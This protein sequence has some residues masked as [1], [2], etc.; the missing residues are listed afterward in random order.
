MCGITGFLNFRLDLAADD[1]RSRVRAM[2]DSLAHRGPDNSGI[3]VDAHAGVALGHRRLAILDLS[4][5]G[6]QPMIS[7]SGRYVITL[8]GE[9]Y[10]Y[11]ELRHQLKEKG[12]RFRGTSDTEVMLAAFEEWGVEACVPKLTGMFAFAVW[13]RERHTLTLARDRLGEKP[14]YYSR[15]GNTFAFASELKA[16]RT[17][18]SFDG[19]IDRDALSAYLR[20]NYIPAPHSI[21]RSILKLEPGHILEV[22]AAQISPPR[23]YWSL[24]QVAKVGIAEPFTGSTGEA[25]NE[26][27]ALLGFTVQ[28][29]MVADVPLGAFLSGG[30][31]SSLVVA[32]MQKHSAR[33]IKTFT[34]GF[35]QKEFDE[36]PYARAVARFLK[37]DHTELYVS[38]EQAMEVIPHLPEIYDEPFSDSSQ[39][40]TYLVAKLAREEVTVS[41]SGDGGDEL[42]GGYD[43][44]E[45]VSKLWK[46]MQGIPFEGRKLLGHLVQSV[47]L[48]AWNRLAWMLP[49]T[50][51]RSNDSSAGDRMHKVAQV[52]DAHSITDLYRRY[53]SH[54]TKPIDWV[55]GANKLASVF[56]K[57]ESFGG[58]QHSTQRMM[59]LDAL[60][61]LPDDILVKLDRAAMS[62]GLETRV[63]LLDHHVVEFAWRIPMSM[64]L[65]DGKGKW[66]LRA[67][68]QKYLPGEMV[69]RPKKGFSVPLADWLRGPLRPWADALLAEKRVREDGYFDP[70]LVGKM[71]NEHLSGERNWRFGLWDLLMFQSWL[72]AQRNPVAA[73]F[74]TIA[75]ATRPDVAVVN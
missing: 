59:Y 41:L 21:Y 73:P 36:A 29:Q 2:A 15:V 22:A 43:S 39:I 20:H 11:R 4:P 49:T 19:E 75:T 33:P 6:N 53:I 67:L 55:V 1:L 32:I 23:A 54:R 14:L 16:L 71:W 48:K 34:I 60:T 56:D 27:D 57:A 7:A 17:Y 64:K 66:L 44:Y 72:D 74:P 52:M 13:D 47:P 3:W 69:E 65:K 63:P 61:Y 46:L 5:L 35:E 42:F 45:V 68:L 9:M 26:V 25:V 12:H 30:I 40:P 62:V 50:V 58:T 18:P 28:R 31:D 24:Y 70:H 37:T 10:N 8:N 38:P 51:M